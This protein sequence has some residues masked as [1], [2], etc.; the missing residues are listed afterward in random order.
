MEGAAS[1]QAEIHSPREKAS[2][3]M[4]I[5]QDEKESRKV[6]RPRNSTSAM[7]EQAAAE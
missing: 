4:V 5:E 1:K 3:V 2:R 7:K 6:W